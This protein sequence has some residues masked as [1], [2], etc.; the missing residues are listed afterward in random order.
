VE[1]TGRV[2]LSRT[3]YNFTD[4][5]DVRVLVGYRAHV[6]DT[7]RVVGVRARSARLRPARRGLLHRT[8]ARICAAPV[9]PGG[10]QQASAPAVRTRRVLRL[11]RRK[12]ARMCQC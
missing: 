1:G 4:A 9:T 8:G 12:P 5:Q 6:S 11:H 3:V 2:Q 7:G 10:L